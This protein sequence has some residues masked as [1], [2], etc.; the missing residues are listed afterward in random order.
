MIFIIVQVDVLSTIAIYIAIQHKEACAPTVRLVAILLEEPKVAHFIQIR[1]IIG[2]K[3][4][5]KAIS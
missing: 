5:L 3:S 2:C 4:I 1:S